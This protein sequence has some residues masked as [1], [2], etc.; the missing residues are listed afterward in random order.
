MTTDAIKTETL[1]AHAGRHAAARCA[2]CRAG[3]DPR[4][5]LYSFAMGLKDEPRCPAC[6]ASAIGRPADEFRRGLDEY[7]HSRPCYREALTVLEGSAPE[8]RPA[9]AAGPSPNFRPRADAE[10]D[11]GDLGCGDL[12]LELRNRVQA[13]PAGA[14]LHLTATDP[15]A[16]ED[17]PAWCR[18]TGNPLVMAAHPDYWIRKG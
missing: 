1:L 4:A 10:W 13:L 8:A 12:A 14:V 15:G 6:L 18:M 16:P 9:A 7:L 17:L 11:A 2:G 3:L 5:L